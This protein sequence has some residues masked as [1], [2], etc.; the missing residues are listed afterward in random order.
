MNNKKIS[1]V[2]AVSLEDGYLGAFKALERLGYQC[3]FIPAMLYKLQNKRTHIKK[4]I[5]EINV[6]QSDLVLWWRAETLNNKELKKIKNRTNM[7]FALYS[8]DDPYQWEMHKDMPQKCKTIDIAFSCCMDSVKMYLDNGCKNAVYCPPGFDQT[9]HYPEYDES[10]QCDISLVCTNLYDNIN[11]TSFHMNRKKL[12]LKLIENFPNLKIH[13]YGP[14]DFKDIFGANYKGWIKFNESHKVFSNSK[15]NICTHIKPFGS[16]YINERVCQILGSGGLLFLDHVKDIDKVLNTAEDCV[17]MSWDL[18]QVVNQ[19]KEILENY[20][21]YE[22]KKLNG[23]KKALNQ[24][25][26][27]N[28]AEI[29]EKNIK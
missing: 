22:Q 14:E 2:G 7:T 11:D 21:N 4:I 6:H 23:L 15:I 18:D 3:F 26:W 10:Y 20:S 13:I 28:W 24:L 12:M 17:I 8:W 29:V 16:M 1:F 25:T 9:T 27:N 5:K 19:I